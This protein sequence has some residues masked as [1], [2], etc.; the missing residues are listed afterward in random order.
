MPIGSEKRFSEAFEALKRVQEFQVDQLPREQELGSRL[1]FREAV[2]PASTLVD[3]FRRLSLQALEDFPEGQ[4]QQVKDQANSIYNLFDQI[5]K[6]DVEQ[7]SPQ[8]ARQNLIEGLKNN[9]PSVFVALHPLIAYSLHRSA[10][11]QRLDSQA[12]ATLQGVEDRANQLTGVLQKH[13]KDAANVLETI[14]KV[15]AE[16][17]VT[18]Q[19]THFRAEAEAHETRAEEWRKRTVRLAIGLA[20]L[21]VGS[22]L[23]HKIPFLAPS[24][25]SDSI[26][27]ITSKLLVFGVVTY[28]LVLSARNFMSHRHNAVVNKH[29]QNALMTHRALVEGVAAS[30]ARDAVMVQA[31]SCIFSPQPTG[32]TQSKNDG[33]SSGPRSVVEILSK[34]AATVL[35]ES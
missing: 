20:L 7:S 19:A 29:R 2:P 12:R 28:M 22:L 16:E 13:E 27:L 26:Q 11:F 21:A 18:Q 24:S 14:R 9:Y 5:L 35:K 8:S 31:A 17:G 25:I 15:A 23:L 30:G 4:L 6:F 1:N 3:L 34:P 32:Y 10:D 33:D